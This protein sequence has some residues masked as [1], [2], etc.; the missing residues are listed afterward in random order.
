MHKLFFA[1]SL[2]LATAAAT[3]AQDL[4]G[5]S[6]STGFYKGRTNISL[7]HG[8]GNF[9][10][11]LFKTAE[12]TEGYAYQGLGPY[13]AKI[14]YALTDHSG[15]G[16]SFNYAGSMIG[17]DANVMGQSTRQKLNWNGFSALIRYNYHF[18][19]G[20]RFDPYIGAGMGFRWSK[21]QYGVDAAEK[22]SVT[23]PSLFPLGFEMTVG[24]RYYLIPNL[25]LYGEGGLAK[26]ILQVG[27]VGSF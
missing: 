8:F 10:Q 24:A 19:T 4:S 17:Y 11:S 20:T 18:M 6:K 15:L 26:G 25:A 23:L 16:V 12:K 5:S 7:G 9:S 21:Y 14:E 13:H 1:L 2:T 22:E 27:L 3:L